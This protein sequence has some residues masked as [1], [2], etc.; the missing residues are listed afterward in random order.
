[1]ME[2]GQAQLGAV[3]I[4]SLLMDRAEEEFGDLS[5]DFAAVGYEY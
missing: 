5:L 4:F 1:M 3:K 2:R